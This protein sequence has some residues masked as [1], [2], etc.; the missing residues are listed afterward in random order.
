MNI[1]SLIPENIKHLKPYVAGRTIAEVMEV[2]RPTR[3]SKLA[4]NENRMGF[5]PVAAHA[6]AEASKYIQD[7][8]DPVS[9]KLR[10]KLSGLHAVDEEDIMITAGSESM[11][12]VICRTFFKAGENAVTADATFVGFY[13]QAGVRGV[14]VKKIPITKNYKFD[15]DGIIGAAKEGAKLVYIANPNNPTGTYLSKAD[16]IRLI[17]GVPENVLIIADE[18]YFEYAGEIE[19]Y[20]KAME[21][22]RDNVIILRTFSKAYG[23]AGLRVGYGIAHPDLITQMTKTRLTFE[24]TTLAQAAAFA[25]LDDSEFIKKSVERVVKGREQLYR[26]FD[27]H[28]VQY[29][30]S[31]SNSVLMIC[32]D[33]ASAVKFTQSMLEQGVILRRTQAFGLPNCIRITIGTEEDMQHFEQSYLNITE[34][35]YS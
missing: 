23:L 11:I 27:E 24:P 12:S 25:A 9:Q 15:V 16:Y 32:D 7:Y 34:E 29:V 22:R 33:D 4:S 28:D 31:I 10:K 1:D 19:D 6:I 17:D 35:I 2:Y 14:K 8:P 20:P 13:V 3:I 30:K 18:A 21:Y 5:S 26:F